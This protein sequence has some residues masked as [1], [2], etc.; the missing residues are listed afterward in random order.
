MAYL[1]KDCADSMIGRVTAACCTWLALI[2]TASAEDARTSDLLPRGQILEVTR[3]HYA[4]AVNS[5]ERLEPFDS[6]AFTD[7]MKKAV[8]EA[9]ADV[10]RAYAEAMRTIV[11]GRRAELKKVQDAWLTYY[12]LNCDFEKSLALAAY[13]DCVVK[14]AVERAVEL[15]NRIGD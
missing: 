7:C 2:C 5:C 6:P 12:R 14:M 8:V 3:S 15:R 11:P 9:D 1:A 4:G 10:N 13:Y